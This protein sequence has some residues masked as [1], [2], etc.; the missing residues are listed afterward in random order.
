[1][2][3]STTASL[4]GILIAYTHTLVQHRQSLRLSRHKTLS[5][6]HTHA[7]VILTTSFFLEFFKPYTSSD[8]SS[9][10]ELVYNDDDDDD[11]RLIISLH[12]LSRPL[13]C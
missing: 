2:L 11:K 1:M 12:R 6:A 4:P 3:S 10:L 5:R 13:D 9:S 8:L 7:Y